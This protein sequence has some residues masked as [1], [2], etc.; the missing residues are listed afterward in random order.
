MADIFI[1]YATVDRPFARRLAD[2][3]EAH[4][5]SVWWDHRSLRGG[6]HFDRVIEEAIRGAKLVI[7]VWSKASVE[8]GWVRDEATLA[9]EE[10]KLVPLRIDTACLPMRFRNIHTIDLASWTGESGSSIS[11]GWRRWTMLL[12]SFMAY[13]SLVEVLAGFKH[14]PRY[15]AFL[16]SS[17]PSFRH[18]S[19]KASMSRKGDCYDNAPMESF[20]SSLKTEL[21]HRTQFRTWREAKAALFEGS[22]RVPG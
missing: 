14:L 22:C 11:L 19:I 7:V 15:A 4:G 20:F 13:R 1:S 9:L 12:S 2:A 10:K 18:S 6:Q 8:S 16:T 17:S 5:W 3:L 21:V